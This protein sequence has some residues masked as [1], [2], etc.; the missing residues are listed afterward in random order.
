[1][2]TKSLVMATGHMIRLATG[3][4]DLV[5]YLDDEQQDEA[6]S[7]TPSKQWADVSV[8]WSG[9]V[10]AGTHTAWLQS[11]QA[12]IWGCKDRWANAKHVPSQP[13]RP[14]LKSLF[15]RSQFEPVSPCT[16][17]SID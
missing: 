15:S 4:A 10:D 17:I 12:N 6:T 2:P 13:L 14:H 5:L 11:P 16:A 7:Y 3:K 1:M 8:F 9:T